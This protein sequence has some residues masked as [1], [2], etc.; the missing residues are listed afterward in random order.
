VHAAVRL[1]DDVGS[2]TYAVIRNANGILTLSRHY[3]QYLYMAQLN[4]HLDPATER[5]LS[6]LMRLRGI[7]T[8]SDAVR[9][10]L[11]ETVERATRARTVVDYSEWIGL[12]KRTALNP[13]PR[14]SSHDDLWG[15]S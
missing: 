3:V 10:A 12:G 4:L 8:K 11:A 2:N 7:R 6:R 14:F 1:A 13:H 5:N 15:G 9:L